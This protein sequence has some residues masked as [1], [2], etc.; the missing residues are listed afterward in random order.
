MILATAAL[1]FAKGSAVVM[2]RGGAWGQ[3]ASS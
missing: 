1:D 3:P 2:T